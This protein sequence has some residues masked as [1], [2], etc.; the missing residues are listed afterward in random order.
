MLPNFNNYGNCYELYSSS[1]D[2]LKYWNLKGLI[3]KEYEPHSN[4]SYHSLSSDG[5]SNICIPIQEKFKLQII[6]P[7]LLFQFMLT[8]DK[9]I[10]IEINI[11]DNYD[12]KRRIFITST[13]QKPQISTYNA[14][15]PILNY[16]FDIWSN[17]LIDISKLTEQCFEMQNF[18]CIDRIKLSGSL[19]I[20]KIYSVSSKDEYILKSIDLG[21]DVPVVN[22]FLYD[23]K[24][25][26]IT[27]NELKIGNQKINFDFNINFSDK[28]IPTT[29]IYK[30]R[31][32]HKNDRKKNMSQSPYIK[33]ILSNNKNNCSDIAMKETQNKK[34]FNSLSK[35][36]KDNLRFANHIPDL[37]KLKNQID[38]ILGGFG[39]KKLNINKMLG[40]EDVLDE[41]SNDINKNNLRNSKKNLMPSPK[42]YSNKKK[43]FE[44]CLYMNKASK[45]N[46]YKTNKKN[47]N[48]EDKK[49]YNFVNNFNI[50]NETRNYTNANSNNYSKYTNIENDNMAIKDIINENEKKNIEINNNNEN[51]N[52]IDNIN[53]IGNIF[54]PNQTIYNKKVNNND[55][56]IYIKEGI[57]EN[58]SSFGFV[59]P[60]PAK[61]E[62]IALNTSKSQ[63]NTKKNNKNENYNKYNNCYDN[64]FD[65]NIY[66]NN[67][68]SQAQ[69]YDS[70]EE[71]AD[72]NTYLENN[73]ITNITNIMNSRIC[74]KL[75]QIDPDIS[76]KKNSINDSGLDFPEI[77]SLLNSQKYNRPYTPPIAGLVPVEQNENK[78]SIIKEI[79]D[80][81]YKNKGNGRKV[82]GEYENLIYDN[83]KELYYDQK[84]NIYYDIQNINNN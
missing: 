57:N 35:K 39:N 23:Y 46:N 77:N 29:E 75:I 43:N 24:L 31:F 56:D 60:S 76:I 79:N 26:Y 25:S 1:S 61:F 62:N 66:N 8:N 7:L 41:S 59:V 2:I 69:L 36:T 6:N 83:K 37:N 65:S 49:K 28:K 80:M 50:K 81:E 78:D 44:K 16:P 51:I 15:I 30:S 12:T 33:E 19:K 47:N 42:N 21:K 58:I 73:N 27:F 74:D 22:F 52:N 4:T 72:Y 14:K 70:I 55:N 9:I 11:R 38:Y 10:S 13:I 71:V 54:N 45:F 68:N 48:D 64:L 34:Q 3:L 5:F 40:L 18:K 53:N 67:Y 17:L 20:R 32:K 63:R 82:I 84:N